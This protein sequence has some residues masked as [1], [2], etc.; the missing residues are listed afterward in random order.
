M[1]TRESMG[2][3]DAQAAAAK[4]LASA[5]KS[6]GPLAVV[7]ADENGDVVH[8]LTQDGASATDIRN[9]ERKA[10]TA[11]FIGRDT[12][13][14][15]QQITADGRTVADWSDPMITTLHG[16]VT[17]RRMGQVVGAI[18]VAG[19]GS[20]DRDEVLAMGAAELLAR[21]AHGATA[22]EQKAEAQAAGHAVHGLQ[23]APPPR[24]ATGK[25]RKAF[26]LPGLAP[27]GAVAPDLVRVGELFFTSGVRGV[28]RATGKIG[29][30]PAEEFALAW[31]NLAALV[32]GAGLSLDDVG[33][34]TVFI[35]SQDY[36]PYISPGWLRLFP[37]KGDRPARKTTSYLLPPGEG[38]Q[39]QA[40]G[41]VGQKRQAIEVKGLT[42]K[43]PLPNGVRMGEYVFSSVIVPWDLSTSLPVVGEE[44][45]TDKCFENMRVF[46]EHA[47]GT[48]DDIALQWVYLNDFA[49]QPYMVDVYVDAWPIGAFQAARKTF[50]YPMGGQIQIQVIGKVGAPHYNF[51]IPGH[52][53]H[54]PIPMAA[55]L[56]NLLCS[57]G[58]SGVD[59][60]S[61]DKLEPVEGVAGQSLHGLRN[62]RALVEAG[63]G[64]ADDIG[65][66]TVL[67]QDYADLEAVDAEWVKMFPDPADRPARQVMR[68][69]VQRRMRAQFHMIAS[70]D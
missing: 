6:D 45:Q 47:G 63:G 55:R 53:H 56:G 65:H 44:A 46:M 37:T 41:V 17:I 24:T 42:H 33:L 48:M 14:Y 60:A 3:D 35:G 67:V 26:S 51:E 8:L 11:A 61:A 52:E 27:A 21:G 36:R 18:G 64:S 29:A 16:G 69:G 43:D 49:Y 34:V 23:A 12:W 13:A 10:Y 4:V 31:D 59:T 2:I 22:R 15:R 62:I 38:V 5:R 58:V 25:R 19:S 7:V 20:E 70:V 1:F 9:A 54:D 30:T 57:S 32:K 40:Y 39:L 66:I 28:D 50:R 68:L